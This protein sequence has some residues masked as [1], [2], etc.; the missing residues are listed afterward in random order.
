[1]LETNISLAPNRA[2]LPPSTWTDERVEQLKTLWADGLSCG[3]IAGELNCGFSRNAVIGK[4][5]RLGLPE[6]AKRKAAA[7]A[8]RRH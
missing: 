8:R 7:K 4:V 1:M 2:N 6:R 5:Y 3:Q